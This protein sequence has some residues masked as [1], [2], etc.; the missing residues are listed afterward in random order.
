[1]SK[2]NGQKE[3]GFVQAIEEGQESTAYINL[4]E[5]RQVFSDYGYIQSALDE[6]FSYLADDLEEFMA[7]K[8]VEFSLN[9]ENKEVPQLF[10]DFLASCDSVKKLPASYVADFNEIGE[11]TYCP[12]MEFHASAAWHYIAER[13]KSKQGYLTV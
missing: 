5:Q 6:C 2:N 9:W 3:Q 10:I 4:E 7:Q 1:M 11:P 12:A 13:E 8:G